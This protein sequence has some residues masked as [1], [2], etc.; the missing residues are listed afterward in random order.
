MRREVT[1]FVL[2]GLIGV[3][4]AL[5]LVMYLL[6]QIPHAWQDTIF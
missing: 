3:L 4:L 6:A 5:V 2:V 1:W